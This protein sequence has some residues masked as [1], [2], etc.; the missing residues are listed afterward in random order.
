MQ[1]F[2]SCTL[3]KLHLQMWEGHYV[4]DTKFSCLSRKTAWPYTV[5]ME[6]ESSEIQCLARYAVYTGLYA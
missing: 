3:M 6:T 2:Y 5:D 1:Y 4:I